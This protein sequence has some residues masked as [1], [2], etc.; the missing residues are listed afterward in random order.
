MEI[1]KNKEIDFYKK[2]I[3]EKE[4]EIITVENK[5]NEKTNIDID[6]IKNI[7]DERLKELKFDYINN[8]N[9]ILDLLINLVNSE[10]VAII[11]ALSIV[12]LGREKEKV[13]EP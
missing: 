4:K 1:I 8:Q 11:I 10:K 13:L 6:R 7:Y 9:N 3:N 5:Y 2:I 12:D